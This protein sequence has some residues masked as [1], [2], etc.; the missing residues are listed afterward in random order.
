MTCYRQLLVR[1]Y[2]SSERLL[3]IGLLEI[4]KGVSIVMTKKN[5]RQSSVEREIVQAM[6][7]YLR[8]V[9]EDLRVQYRS[10]QAEADQLQKS[11]FAAGE[12]YKKVSK[13]GK[14]V[15]RDHAQTNTNRRVR[16]K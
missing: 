9:L 8:L 5:I 7:A 16:R 14:E 4:R 13:L 6:G 2:R 1:W 12:I 10:I 11:G 15:K 3:V